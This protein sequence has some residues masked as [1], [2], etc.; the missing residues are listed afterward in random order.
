M[1]IS[2]IGM[3]YVGIQL[4][5]AFGQENETIGF[6]LDR[7]KLEAYRSGEDPTGE[8][9]KEKLTNASHLLF[10]DHPSD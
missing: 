7:A 8:V 1:K 2:V 3:G 4:A 5:S 10:S 6:D 9:S